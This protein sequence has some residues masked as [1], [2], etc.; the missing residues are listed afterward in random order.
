VDGNEL[1]GSMALWCLGKPRWLYS[2]SIPVAWTYNDD[3]TLTGWYGDTVWSRT[4]GE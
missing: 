1:T 4:G 3:D 2:D